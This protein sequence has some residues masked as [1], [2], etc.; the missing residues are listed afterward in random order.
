[1]TASA[2]PHP[3]PGQ[4]Y[5]PACTFDPDRW[6]TTDPDPQAVALCRACPRRWQCAR[7]ACQTPAAQGLWAGV[8]LPE[9]GR[10]RQFAL[11]VLR[12]LAQH[13]GYPVETARR[14][15]RAEDADDGR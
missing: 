2:V 15:P 13:G 4:A 9:S 8:V 3:E 12:S 14:R 7:E 5:V 10:R 6:T 11:R 1:M